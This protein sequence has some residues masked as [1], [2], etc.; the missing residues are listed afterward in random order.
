MITWE[1]SAEQKLQ[2]ELWG[3]FTLSLGKELFTGISK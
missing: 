2:H 3:F 1:F